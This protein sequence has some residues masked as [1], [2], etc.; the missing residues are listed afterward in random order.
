MRQKFEIVLLVVV[1]LVAGMT[2]SRLYAQ[3]SLDEQ[4]RAQYT[5]VKMGADSG[6]AAVVEQGTILV[7]KKG[8][9]LS[10]PYADQPVAT[11]YQDGAVHSP[12]TLMMGARGRADGKVWQATNNF[13]DAS[14]NESL[15]LQNRG[16]PAKG[17]SHHGHRGLRFLQ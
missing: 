10:V 5:L 4:L 14:R 15:S 13:P 6:G 16:E 12:S 3:V 9:I 1:G 7:I 17:P 8:G 11:H 2:S